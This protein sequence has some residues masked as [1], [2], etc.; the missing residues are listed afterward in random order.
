MLGEGAVSSTYPSGDWVSPGVL[1]TVRR[2]HLAPAFWPPSLANSPLPPPLPAR[3]IF[4]S[5]ENKDDGLRRVVARMQGSV[6]VHIW[7]HLSG[8]GAVPCP[9]PQTL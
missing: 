7:S 4:N 1:S 9:F 6:C 3:H 8:C 2:L 5:I